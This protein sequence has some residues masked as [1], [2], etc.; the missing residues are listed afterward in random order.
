MIYNNKLLPPISELSIA[1]ENNRIYGEIGRVNKENEKVKDRNT[2]K[3]FHRMHLI[4]DFFNSVFVID[5]EV[6][7]MIHYDLEE[8]PHSNTEIGYLVAKIKF[9]P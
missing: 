3:A 1:I 8:L 2:D 7:E 5:E 4:T 9:Y 6:S